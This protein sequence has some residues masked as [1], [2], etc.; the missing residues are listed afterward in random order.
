MVYV[1]IS[2]KR[3]VLYAENAFR[4]DLIGPLSKAAAEAIVTAPR[5]SGRMANAISSR[6][7]KE[8]N[9]IVGSIGIFNSNLVEA[10]RR[11]ETGTRPTRAKNLVGITKGRPAMF[12]PRVGNKGGMVFKPKG[13]VTGSY[14]KRSHGVIFTDFVK[15]APPNR[16]ILRSMDRVVRR[17]NAGLK[18]NL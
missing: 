1:K 13:G 3:A 14:K 5:D 18:E 6:I 11:K 10:R 7:R 15:A 9:Q 16:F 17:Y 8:G 12:V 4:R 2:P